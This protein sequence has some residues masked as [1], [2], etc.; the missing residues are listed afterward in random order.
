M[1]IFVQV[2]FMLMKKG[3]NYKQPAN[4]AAARGALAVLESQAQSKGVRGPPSPEPRT[5]SPGVKLSC[6]LPCGLPMIWNSPF[7]IAPPKTRTS[8]IRFLG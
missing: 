3:W 4:R 2:V 5:T 8:T 1:Y 7:A 6:L